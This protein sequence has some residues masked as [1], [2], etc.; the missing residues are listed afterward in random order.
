MND[1]LPDHTVC[2]IIARNRLVTEVIRCA[3]ARG[4]PRGAHC[5]RSRTATPPRTQSR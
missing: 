2:T 4:H 5:I 3:L 1:E